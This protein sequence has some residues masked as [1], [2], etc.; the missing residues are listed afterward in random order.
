ME[1]MFDEM[2]RSGSKIPDM[3]T[4]LQKKGW[5][6]FQ[7]HDNWV[8]DSWTIDEKKQSNLSLIGAYILVKHEN[9]FIGRCEKVKRWIMV[10][11]LS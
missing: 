8:N 6:A 2:K 11:I 9:S 5:V 1:A 4:Y 10:N 3:V 7:H